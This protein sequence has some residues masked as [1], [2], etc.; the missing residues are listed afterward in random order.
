[1]KGKH[2]SGK[3]AAVRRKMA[4]CT[5]RMS[6]RFGQTESEVGFSELLVVF[7]MVKVQGHR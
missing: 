5:L 6:H 3:A 1:M 7:C 4:E 2:P